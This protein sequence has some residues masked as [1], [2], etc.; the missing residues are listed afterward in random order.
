MRLC[1]AFAL[2]CW[3]PA[4]AWPAELGLFRP[5]EAQQRF[6]DELAKQYQALHQTGAQVLVRPD[7]WLFF[8][9][10]LRLLSVGKFWG[11]E[12]VTAARSSAHD[13]ADPAPAIID[14][15]NQLKQRGIALLLVPVPPKA[16]VY[17]DKVL[18]QSDLR[19]ENAAPYLTRFYDELRDHGV[20]V[21]DLAPLFQERRES[22]HGAIFCKTDTHWSGAG[23]VA[24]AQIMA[25]KVRATMA[26]PRQHDYTAEWKQI[27][28]NGDLVSLLPP[29]AAR[30]GPETASVRVVADKSTGAAVQPD[31]DSPLLLL[32]DSHTLVYHDFLTERSG[33]LDQLAD[34]LG[35]APDLLGTRGSGAT[36][37]R[38]SLYRRSHKD[39]GYL[40]KKKMIIW[41]FSAREFTEADAW[42]RVPIAK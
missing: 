10:E 28:F 24:A 1:R 29:S 16:A 34:E 12:A 42:A 14:F 22:E 37:V 4:L 36:A 25:A 18:P 26:T 7:G 35:F 38:V 17:P 9:P 15:C 8:A 21:L 2:L 32:G 31:A 19:S 40:S 41:C 5:S 3:L 23:C 6:S 39:P 13:Q 30:P 33:L 20:D 27:Q 11:N